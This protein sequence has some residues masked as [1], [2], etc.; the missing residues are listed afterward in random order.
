MK[1]GM[2][3]RLAAGLAGAL[4]L[5]GCDEGDDRH[6]ETYGEVVVAGGYDAAY[7]YTVYVVDPYGYPVP[8]A[9][10]AYALPGYETAVVYTDDSGLA[11]FYFDAPA[12]EA[13]YLDVSG[14]YYDPYSADLYT[15][16]DTEVWMEVQ[17]Q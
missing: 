10:V 14:G 7:V 11:T 13:L 6:H 16:A 3:G 5:A 2:F 15:G 4:M 1:T 12:E 17:L 8:G 9:A